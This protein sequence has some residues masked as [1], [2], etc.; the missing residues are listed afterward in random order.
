MRG[1]SEIRRTQNPGDC[2]A[3]TTH[4]VRMRTTHAVR[5]HYASV[6]ASVVAEKGPFQGTRIHISGF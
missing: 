1:S 4:A 5:M 3:N 2:S 6:Y